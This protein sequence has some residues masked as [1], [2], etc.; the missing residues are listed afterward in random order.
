MNLNFTIS[1]A[2]LGALWANCCAGNLVGYVRDLNWYARSTDNL[3]YGTGYYEYGVNANCEQSATAAGAAATDVLGRFQMGS[4]PAGRYTVASWDVWWRSAYAFGVVVPTSGSTPPV[5]LRLHGTMWGYPAFWDDAGWYEFGQTFEASGPISMIYLRCPKFDG[6]PTYTLTIHDGQPGGAQ[7]GVARSFGTGDQRP[8][9][10]YGEMPTVAGRTYYLRVRVPASGKAGVIMQMD[11]R[12]DDSDP[13]PGGCLWLG[14][15]GNVTPHTDR[16]LGVVIMSDDDGL[17][18]DLFTRASGTP[19]SEATSVGQTFEARGINLISAAFWLADPAAPTYQVQ[20]RAEGPN[21]ELVGIAKRG[22]PA[23]LT[24]DPE[25]IVT[26]SPGECPLTPGNRYYAEI[27]RVGGGVFRQV[28]VNR[29]NPY[30]YGTAYQN[31]NPIATVDLAGTLIQEASLGAAT[32]PSPLFT[33]EAAVAESDRGPDQLTVRWTTDQPANS[34]VEFAALV[35]PYTDVVRD[36]NLVT[37]HVVTLGNLCPHTRY[38]WRAT[39]SAP[40]LNTAASLDNAASTL[41]DRANLLLNPGFETGSGPSPRATVPGWSKTDGVDLKASDGS[42]YYGI[43]PRT[44]QWLYEGAV[45][46]NSSEGYIYQRVAVTRGRD[47]TFSAWVT[48]WMRENNTWKY[49]VWQDRGRLIHVRIGIDPTGGTNPKASSVRWTPRTY[50]H[51]HYSNLATTTTA[52]AENITV[53]VAMQGEGGQWHLYG[54]D[55]CVLTETVP[56]RPRLMAP[57]FTDDGAFEFTLVGQPGKTSAIEACSAF[58]EWSPLTNLVNLTGQ[59]R[60]RHLPASAS[61]QLYYRAVLQ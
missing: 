49:D 7:V 37:E 23:R 45:N 1:L 30:S 22:K 58:D 34:V 16:D 29:A 55:D 54:V 19:I 47:Y 44:G 24:A 36:T 56:L 3:P 50:S 39:S 10:G 60:F 26:W 27:T 51:L 42:W 43:P 17:L 6:A 2:C 8:V 53:F 13:M 46:G 14:S 52:T 33:A 9:Y 35:P 38:H 15:P 20:I 59:T 25:M 5:N 12:P 41:P 31:G 11:P 18:T 4:L 28:Y 48:T 57:G 40:G 32:R 61:N 21:G